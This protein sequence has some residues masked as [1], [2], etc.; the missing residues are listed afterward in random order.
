MSYPELANQICIMMNA[1]NI[2][3]NKFTE[4]ELFMHIAAF[5]IESIKT[6]SIGKC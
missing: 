5:W 1:L 3:I 2:I 4:M 6:T